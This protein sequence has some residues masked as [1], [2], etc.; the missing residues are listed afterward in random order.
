MSPDSLATAAAPLAVHRHE[1]AAAWS[2]LLAALPEPQRQVLASA[3]GLLQRRAVVAWRE[4]RILGL[5]FGY[6]RPLTAYLKLALLWAPAGAALAGELLRAFE[7]LA[8]AEG[9]SVVKLEQGEGFPLDGAALRDAGYR[10]LPPP[11]GAELETL[12]P[13]WVRP[14]LNSWPDAA[15]SYYRQTT[16][17]TCGPCALGMALEHQGAA[18]RLERRDELA[19]WREATTIYAPAGPGGCDPFGLAVAARKRGLRATV[20]LS[21]QEAVLLNRAATED[22]REVMR[23]VQS[24]FRREAAALGATVHWRA[25]AMA[26]IGA[27]LDQGALALL[28]IDEQLMHAEGAPHWVLAHARYGEAWL[29]NDPWIDGHLGETWVDGSHLP[30]PERHLDRMCWYGEPAY[31]SAVVLRPG[32][33]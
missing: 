9:A 21:S 10:P 28:L 27:A 26:E 33:L 24:E 19:L 15:P 13:G 2:A 4:G 5:A 23:F 3:G 12:P 17:M 25:F 1:E 30:I 11:A 18:P 8:A 29:V 32:A 20:Y 14:L 7:R 31:R 22:K 16:G 6:R